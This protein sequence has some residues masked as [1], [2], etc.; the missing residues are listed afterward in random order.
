MKY[1]EEEISMKKAAIFVAIAMGLVACGDKPAADPSSTTTTT[2]S[3]SDPAAGSAT[4]PAGSSAT[5]APA[6][7]ATPAK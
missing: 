4:P 2:T 3:P 6:S 5:P 1:I 7:P